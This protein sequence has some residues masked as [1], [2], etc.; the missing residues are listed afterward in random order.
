MNKNEWDNEM[1]S[2]MGVITKAITVGTNNGLARDGALLAAQMAIIN[3]MNQEGM[4]DKIESVIK[5]ALRV[6]T[7][8]HK[9]MLR[10]K[11]VQS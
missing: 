3:Y 5:E 8:T 9:Q 4:N 7:E 2:V 10:T 11:V 6:C 1:M